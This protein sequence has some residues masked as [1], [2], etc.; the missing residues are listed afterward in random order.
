MGIYDRDWYRDKQNSS[1][2]GNNNKISREEAERLR[3]KMEGS[4]SEPP[5]VD[6]KYRFE[7]TDTPTGNNKQSSNEYDSTYGCGYDS[8]SIEKRRGR[9]KNQGLSMKPMP[10]II[11]AVVIGYVVAV[12]Y[13][14]A[15]VNS[16]LTDSGMVQILEMTD[17]FLLNMSN[18]PSQWNNT[19]R[20]S[21]RASLRKSVYYA[22]DTYAPIKFS[23]VLSASKEMGLYLISNRLSTG[24]PSNAVNP[25][26]SND[27]GYAYV[28]SDG[29]NIRSGPSVN[30]GVVSTLRMNSRVQVISKTG[31]WWKIKYGNTEG[32]VNSEYLSDS[33]QLNDASSQIA[34]PVPVQLNDAPNQITT[35]VPAQSKYDSHFDVLQLSDGTLAITAYKGSGKHVVFPA[36]LFGIRVSEIRLN[37]L[38]TNTTLNSFAIEN[39][40]EKIASSSFGN[41]ATAHFEYSFSD[42]V[43]PNSILE[44]GNSAF[45]RS[46]K[47]KMLVT[48]QLPNRLKR[49]GERAFSGW[50]ED[51]Y[52]GPIYVKSVVLPNSLEYVGGKAFGD[53]NIGYVKIENEF[54]V[55]GDRV[56]RDSKIECIEIGSNFSDRWLN[57]VFSDQGF[58][59]FY[60]S[61]NRRANIYKYNGK[62]WTIGTRQDVNNILAR[63]NEVSPASNST[64]AV[65]VEPYAGTTRAA[66][67]Q[68]EW[69][70]ANE[71]YYRTY[72]DIP[73][74][75]RLPSGETV[76]ERALS[77]RVYVK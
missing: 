42:I 30:N 53:L 74:N 8:P 16:F 39:G 6:P 59:N 32:Y 65:P 72:T 2:E 67:Y 29:L 69:E 71:E 60:I 56:F 41:L 10:V 23:P 5:K 66:S 13:N 20:A 14:V 43:L 70:E 50:G 44:I 4:T 36:Y 77:G 52:I 31:V 58:I 12:G 7:F 27:Y 19:L 33:V 40:I 37:W 68:R 73:G 15:T 21:F 9:F 34:A 64:S 75:L 76:E 49:I 57:R 47:T 25:S 22:Y 1:G 28:K 38:S 62:I 24:N 51:S 18:V 17:S 61:Q 54:N 35:L 11:L 55:D 3:R 26:S 45:H 63:K 48:L 46:F